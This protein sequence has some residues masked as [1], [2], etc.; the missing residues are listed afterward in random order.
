MAKQPKKRS[1]SKPKSR[2]KSRKRSIN[3]P[4]VLLV[5]LIIVVFAIIISYFM[6]GGNFQQYF[7]QVKEKV[8]TV[9]GA[10]N[11]ETSDNSSTTEMTDNTQKITEKL[12]SQKEKPIPKTALEGTW[13][14]T[15]NGAMLT[16]KG[17]TFELELISIEERPKL[18]GHFKISESS[19]HLVNTLS[20]DLCGM[21]EGVYHFEI[22]ADELI[23][24]TQN[25]PCNMRKENLSSDWFKL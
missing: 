2:T 6:A 20:D 3:K 1:S 16:F 18:K 7:N 24:S 21:K 14:S 22:K 11:P 17:N 13:V 10:E 4:G 5:L 25:D 9:S 12:P 8:S 15:L 19:L 23:L